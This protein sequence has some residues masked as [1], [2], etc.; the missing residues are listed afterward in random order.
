MRIFVLFSFKVRKGKILRIRVY[1]PNSFTKAI[2][3]CSKVFHDSSLS[4]QGRIY[5]QKL[6]NFCYFE[7]LFSKDEKLSPSIKQVYHSSSYAGNVLPAMGLFKDQA[8][9]P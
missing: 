1:Q 5:F 7:Q 6:E 3:S 2:I 9:V 4:K 8:G